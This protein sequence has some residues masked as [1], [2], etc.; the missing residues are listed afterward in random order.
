MIY[1]S[2]F[3]WISTILTIVCLV[4]CIG[5]GLFVLIKWIIGKIKQK[6]QIKEDL[7]QYNK[8]NN[9]RLGSKK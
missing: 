4:W 9:R 1:Q 3:S 2:V 6:K 5:L 8:H 7:E